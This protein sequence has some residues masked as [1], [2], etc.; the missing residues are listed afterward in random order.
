MRPT[1]LKRI[2]IWLVGAVTS[3]TLLSSCWLPEQFETE[4]R[5]TSLGAY[6][7]TYIGIITYAPLYG[8]IVRGEI[9]KEDADRQIQQYLKF[10][11][12]DSAFKEINSIGSGR[13]QVKYMKEGQFAGNKQSFNFISR[14]GAM[15][16]LRT[17]EDAKM[18]LGGSG[19]ALL[20][21]DRFEEV[22]LKM[23]GLVRV[24]TDAEVLE[25]NAN[26][27]RQSRTPGF[28]QYDWRIRSLRD[29]PPRLIAKLKVDPR[30]GVPAYGSGASNVDTDDGKD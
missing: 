10:L 4:V 13:F 12:G 21:A 1:L 5:F 11:K 8:K 6:G 24:V 20:Y 17:T 7:V 26:F 15:F 25:H 16:R 9:S 19:Q 22:G 27:V 30:T 3:L 18:V 14:Q 28:V 29:P 23:Q 2:T